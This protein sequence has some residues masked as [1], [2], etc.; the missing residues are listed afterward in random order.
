[1]EKRCFG[2]TDMHVSALGFGGAEIGFEK[3][4]DDVVSRL[5][6]DALDAGLNVIDT[7]E[8]Y[9]Q[10]E[11][12]IGRA[13]AGRRDH[14][15]LFT[16]CGHPVEPS[17]GDW[18]PESL[19]Q[20]IERSL[21]RLKTDRVDLVQLHSCSEDELRKGDVI[22]ALQRARERGHT[23]Y[24]G[25]SGDGQAA[26]YAVECGAFD[27]LQTSV[28]IADQQAIDLTLP[29]A[30]ERR[31]GVIAKRPIA[32]AVWRHAKKPENAYVQPY[33]ERINKLDY[34]FL[35]SGG[36]KSISIALR[37]T[38]SIPGVHTAIVGTSKPGRWRENAA[39][40]QA[41]PLTP[42]QFE[43]IRARWREVADAK[44]VGQT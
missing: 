22:A 15:Y 10:S 6:G 35:G 11:E 4:S 14:F 2:K 31:M 9:L 17:T 8:C 13:A 40:L 42:Q 28:S 44:W 41:G 26:R 32:N 7:A 21:K 29:L 30:Q 18:R 27:S 20:S 43:L 33:W 19:L 1:M 16:K 39:L 24:I 5:L 23:R 36:E 37:F 25:Y 34:D 3:A 38:L 12:L